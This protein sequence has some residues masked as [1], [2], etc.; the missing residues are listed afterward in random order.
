MKERRIG[1]FKVA[2][3]LLQEAIDTG[4]GQNLFSGMVPLD[5]QR[6]WM[7]GVTTFIAWHASFMPIEEGRMTP[8]YRATFQAGETAPTWQHVEGT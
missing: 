3:K 5:I 4:H 7:S 1:R 6:E 2:D 8:E